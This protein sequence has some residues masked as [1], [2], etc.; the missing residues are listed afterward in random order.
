M[1]TGIEQYGITYGLDETTKTI[2]QTGFDEI[3][4]YTGWENFKIPSYVWDY[5]D[6]TERDRILNYAYDKIYTKRLD[7]PYGTEYWDDN[8]NL[9]KYFV[10]YYQAALWIEWRKADIEFADAGADVIFNKY[11]TDSGLDNENIN[12]WSDYYSSPE[13]NTYGEIHSFPWAPQGWWIPC[14]Y[15][16][17]WVEPAIKQNYIYLY[18][19]NDNTIEYSTDSE[20]AE[21]NYLSD[22]VFDYYNTPIADWDDIGIAADWPPEAFGIRTG[23][24]ANGEYEVLAGSARFRDF[25]LMEGSIQLAVLLYV[26]DTVTVADMSTDTTYFT[27]VITEVR[28]NLAENTY[29][30]RIADPVTA[31][32][33]TVEY[34]S[35][36]AIDALQEAIEAHGGTFSTEMTTTETVFYPDEPQDVYQFF[37]AVSYAVGGVLQYGR[38]GVYCLVAN[39][40]AHGLND[41]MVIADDGP[42]IE[43]RTSDYANYVQATIDERWM[44]TTTT[45]E[46]ESYS[47][48]SQSYSATRLGE[49]IQSETISLG[50][51][52]LE[53]TY[54]YDANGYMT[55]KQHSEEGSGLGAVKKTSLIEWTGISVDGNQYNVDELHEEFTYCQLYD[56]STG[57]FYNSW[58]PTSKTTR[59]W[60][61]DLDGM[62]YLEE[63]IWGT[64]PLFAGNINVSSDLYPALGSLIRLHKYRGGAVVNPS[65]GPLEGRGIF[66]K[67]N[68][69]HNGFEDVGGVPTGTV[70]YVYAGTETRSVSP[71]A[72]EMCAAE[73]ENEVHIIAGAKDPAA[74]TALGQHKY[75]TQAVALNTSTGMQ[76]FAKGVLYE[77]SRI[78][79]AN[80]STAMGSVLP[81]D[82]VIWR[83]LEWT[84]NGV[85][86]NLDGA[87]DG[88]EIATQSTLNRL[89]GALSKEPVTWTEDVRN[90]INKRV[91]QFDN[92]SRGKVTGRA[93]K[94]RYTVQIEGKADPIEAKALNDDPV[95]VDASVLLVRPTGKNQPWVLLNLSK[96]DEI[97]I[98]AD[99]EEN[100]TPSADPAPP[101]IT[102][103]TA[104]QYTTTPCDLRTLSWTFESDAYDLGVDIDLGDGS[105]VIEIDGYG[106]PQTTTVR[107]M[108]I[109]TLT[110]TITPWVH[111]IYGTK[112]YGDPVNLTSAMVV[113]GPTISSIDT[114][115]TVTFGD[116]A[117]ITATTCYFDGLELLI[118]HGDGTGQKTYCDISETGVHSH[119][120]RYWRTGTYTVSAKLAFMQA[121]GERWESSSAV[122]GDVIVQA[123]TTSS[124]TIVIGDKEYCLLPVEGDFAYSGTPAA[125]TPVTLSN[126]GVAGR[127][128]EW[129]LQ[130]DVTI[131]NPEPLDIAAVR[132]ICP[133]QY[134]PDVACSPEGEQP[135]YGTHVEAVWE[136][137]VAKSSEGQLI[138][139]DR[140]LTRTSIGAEWVL[141]TTTQVLEETCPTSD[142]KTL[143]FTHAAYDP[144]GV[145][146]RNVQAWMDN[147]TGFEPWML[148]E[149]PPVQ[150]WFR[151]L[152][153][154][155]PQIIINVPDTFPGRVWRY[156]EIDDNSGGITVSNVRLVV[157]QQYVVAIS[158][159]IPGGEC[160]FVWSLPPQ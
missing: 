81:F 91:G 80:I 87:S 119:D 112:T 6:Q 122:T 156:L 139:R 51:D 7:D 143:K 21:G 90:A 55:K 42:T 151:V 99:V 82:T 53:I 29:D 141:A 10:I 128:M 70:G 152:F 130:F 12:M 8:A 109:D 104:D 16:G 124:G 159:I 115:S 45:P 46:T 66:K 58:V 150:M 69:V 13:K 142:S 120:W 11:I 72:L 18:D 88:L 20:R 125:R 33:G 68:Y 52:S 23:I 136:M 22:S 147:G 149:N 96:E 76:N 47:I 100:I 40:A 2:I 28:Q 63:E 34:A 123:N 102:S 24:T 129:Y 67:Y 73:E 31:G 85:T 148:S 27:G 4:S 121:T 17:I 92:V 144:M 14:L 110:P 138:V 37:R 3:R 49:Q 135:N 158:E 56:N 43:E 57:T 107:F 15:I 94:R 153:G 5:V 108:T 134:W 1:P 74:I 75:E 19:A 155:E 160:E 133:R 84:I 26:G 93:G 25:G 38:D 30:Y 95:P 77:K 78:R 41:S 101:A 146:S 97:T 89:A 137:G 154:W 127:A 157:P 118:D 65:A 61:V 35:G 79:R 48:G 103:F 44:T 126:Y 116:V 113:N 9:P 50:G 106:E 32:G 36:N 131:N 98:T 117:T 140:H 60:Q 54:T 111:N 71:P 62:A 39:P 64:E 132:L 145:D 59:E 105:D 86:V 83:G 114:G